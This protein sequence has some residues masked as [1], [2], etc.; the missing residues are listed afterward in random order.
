LILLSSPANKKPV[1]RN[2]ERHEHASHGAGPLFRD[3]QV[4]LCRPGGISIPDTR[5]RISGSLRIMSA[6]CRMMSTPPGCEITALLRSKNTSHTRLTDSA[7]ARSA[8]NAASTNTSRS[9]AGE[10][11]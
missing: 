4:L 5:Q 6:I 8:A 1:A 9:K 10:G 2:S 11:R 3:F 7:S